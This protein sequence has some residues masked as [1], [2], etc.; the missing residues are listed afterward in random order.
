MKISKRFYGDVAKEILKS[1]NMPLVGDEGDLNRKIHFK[2]VSV[3]GH[4]I[5]S[6]EFDVP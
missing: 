1:L 3:E 5:V 6:V 4:P 2:N